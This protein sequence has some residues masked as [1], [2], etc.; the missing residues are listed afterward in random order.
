MVRTQRSPHMDV[1]VHV[2]DR[3]LAGGMIME[4]PVRMEV[5][6]K[7]SYHRPAGCGDG[8]QLGTADVKVVPFGELR[9]QY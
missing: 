8:D 6:V 3:R 4:H 5:A 2:P 9:R 7:V 1:V